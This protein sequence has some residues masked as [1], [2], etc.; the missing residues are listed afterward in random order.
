MKALKK[1]ALAF[2]F[3]AIYGGMALL[4]WMK[5][6]FHTLD[7]RLEPI[8]PTITMYFT[9]AYTVLIALLALA[10]PIHGLALS[11]MRRYN[12]ATA[13]EDDR[14]RFNKMS[15]SAM[16]LSEIHP[17]GF[18]GRL[19]LLIG[20]TLFLMVVVGAAIN[21]Y[22]VTAAW[23]MV[24]ETIWFFIDRWIRHLAIEGK[25]VVDEKNQETRSTPPPLGPPPPWAQMT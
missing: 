1:V 3:Y 8:V 14:D 12:P 4:L 24:M 17:R 22:T 18:F 25:K 11:I 2:V 16:S 21:G 13:D 20:T 5:G 10:V 19:S 6:Y 7:P 15:K 9:V 23:L